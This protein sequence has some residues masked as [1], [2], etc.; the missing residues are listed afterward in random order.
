MSIGPPS[1]NY[2]QILKFAYFGLI[3]GQFPL[4]K[5]PNQYPMVHYGGQFL[6]YKSDFWKLASIYTETARYKW[7]GQKNELCFFGT[8]YYRAA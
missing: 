1:K 3:F 6:R 5:S 8:P 4:I 7:P 2:D